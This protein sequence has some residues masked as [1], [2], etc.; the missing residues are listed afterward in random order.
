MRKLLYTLI[1]TLLSI[2][3]IAQT[4][5]YIFVSDAGGFNNPPWQILRYDLN[6][7]NPLVFIPSQTFEDQNVG[8]P[9]D[10]LLLEDQNVILISCLVGNKITRHNANTGD[11]IDDFATVAGGPTRMKIG[12]DDLIYVTQWNLS[13]NKILRFQQ[14]GT[15]VDE[16]TND[17]VPRGIGLDWDTNNN[18]YVT[19][20]NGNLVTQFNDT[21]IS[22]G[23]FI[24]T[25]LN[26]PTNVMREDDGNFLVLN[27]SGGSIERFDSSG[28]FIE[29]FTS[30]VTQ[31]EGIAINP[32]YGNYL[33]GNGGPGRVDEFEPDGTYVGPVFTDGFGGLIQPNAV[34]VIDASLG[35][36]E[37]IQN[38]TLLYPTV[39]TVFNI[40]F[41][42]Q[43]YH[44]DLEVLT[45][46]GQRIA[47]ITKNQT[48][49]NASNLP[50]GIYF[51]RSTKNNRLLQ[52]I[53]IK[54]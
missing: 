51:V 18:L 3:T 10:I 40:K 29:T 2:S 6:G 15:F 37:S 32:L 12:P 43:S 54:K 41:N 7:E 1:F 30:E 17:G 4:D 48:I 14:D 35:I 42:T 49:W 20:Y 26:G 16:Y 28:N 45:I 50:E 31:P 19:S 33:I 27:W 39:G 38:D 47:I 8:W 24:T 5:Y 9:Q 34:V 11:Y 21:G 44:E 25:N 13:D 53:I 36:N 22:Q 46:Q 23:N 52:K